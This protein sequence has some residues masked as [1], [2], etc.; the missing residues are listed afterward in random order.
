M[1]KQDPI[2][3]HYTHVYMTNVYNTKYLLDSCKTF[4]ECIARFQSQIQYF[5]DLK[6]LCRPYLK[7]TDRQG[8]GRLVEVEPYPD[9][10]MVISLYNV[11]I[12]EVPLFENYQF[13]NHLGD[14]EDL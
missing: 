1:S 2:T 13:D 8:V 9:Q 4:D 6:K 7:S 10:R 3:K 11:P 5:K 12:E 14:C